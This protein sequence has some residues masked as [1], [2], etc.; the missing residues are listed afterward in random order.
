MKKWLNFIIEAVKAGLN[1]LMGALCFVK[2]DH[3]VAYHINPYGDRAKVDYYYSIYDKLA[4]R[5]MQFLVFSALAV[6]AISVALSIVSLIVKG[7]KK[8]LI[9]S[10][11]VFLAAAIFFLALLIYSMRVLQYDY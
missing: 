8:I 6:M 10:H 3:E 1:V 11:I 7:N 5:N 4:G 9:I 2:L